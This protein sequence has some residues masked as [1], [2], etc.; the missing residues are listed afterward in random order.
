MTS[1]FHE[2]VLTSRVA[3]LLVH[4]PAGTYVDATIGGGGHAQEILSRLTTGRLIGLDRDPDAI[5]WCRER[6]ADS[7]LLFH[8]RFSILRQ[9]L[10]ASAPSGIQGVLFDLGVSSHQLENAKRGFSYLKDGPLDLRMD[11]TS[12][13]PATELVMGLSPRELRL[14]L[15]TYGE[16]R[17][18]ARIAKA[19]A[20]ARTRGPIETTVQLAAIISQAVP[21]GGVKALARTFQALRIAVNEELEELDRGLDSAWESLAV[22]GRLVVLAYHSLE[23]RKVKTFFASKTRGCTC[24]PGLPVCTCGHEAV[25]VHLARR[26][27]RPSL[28]EISSNRRARGARLRAIRKL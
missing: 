11:P 15:R 13:R 23:D 26:A 18:A 25:A 3:D 21:A 10:L 24:P 16:E 2:P 7:V 17:Q 28:A 4:D 9:E 6:F 22:G 8:T 19:I 14:I 20:D 27:L 12:G 5:R 1:D